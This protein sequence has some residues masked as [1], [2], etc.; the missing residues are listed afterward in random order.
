MYYCYLGEAYYSNSPDSTLSISMRGIKFADQ[1][2]AQLRDT[3]YYKHLSV[4]LN[5]AAFVSQKQGNTYNAIQL[6]SR[7]IEALGQYPDSLLFGAAYLNLGTLYHDIGE[8]DLSL[9]Y[10]SKINPNNRNNDPIAFAKAQNIVSSIYSDRGNTTEAFNLLRSSLVIFGKLKDTADIGICNDKLGELHEK[11]TNRDSALYYFRKAYTLFRK[12]G[13]ISGIAS[14]SVNIANILLKNNQSDS[15][16]YYAEIGFNAASSINYPKNLRDASTLISAI[17][18]QRGNSQKALYYYKIYNQNDGALKSLT[19]VKSAVREQLRIDLE[20]KEVIA[21]VERE[22]KEAIYRESIK[23]QKIITGSSVAVGILLLALLILALR[24]YR[25]KTSDNR[26]ISAQKLLIENKNRELIDSI[27]YAEL[28]QQALLPSAQL[29]Q[30]CFNESFLYFKPR[31][32]VSGDFYW[33][34]H[35]N[36]TTWFAICDSTG[37]G[38]PGAF[39]ALLNMSF[40]SEAVIERKLQS[41]DAVFA[42]VRDRLM[43]RL[44]SEDTQDG[45]DGILFQLSNRKLVYAAANNAPLIIRKG[46]FIQLD[47]D[48]IPVGKPPLELN[49]F[50]RFEIQL[51]PGDL[52]I[53][54]TD[55]YA[56]QFG[57]PNGKKFRYK[58][59]RELLLAHAEKPMHEIERALHTHFENWKG[60]EEQVDDVLVAGFR[61]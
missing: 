36:D 54:F 38:V 60:S 21:K 14:S 57:G 34:N 4:L 27:N 11:T 58:A 22:K 28:I 56:D 13:F 33:L 55:G 25:V 49:T 42:F 7:C 53:A 52:V 40:M 48:N 18:E 50:S 31:N 23:R 12:I 44:T 59:L 61:V 26:K 37:H 6:Y 10:L 8:D 47:A 30:T 32:I 24:S 19:A 15:A 51:A 3:A 29:M 5:N 20:A 9:F 45:M 1:L 16:L 17:W 43:E 41:P 2:P 35:A 46:Q 39:L